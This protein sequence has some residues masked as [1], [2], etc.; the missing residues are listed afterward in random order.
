MKKPLF[1]ILIIILLIS[2][3]VF[4]FACK[5]EV[6]IEETVVKTPEEDPDDEVAEQS[7]EDT[8]EE[9][10]GETPEEEAVDE[11]AQE[12]AET[13]EYSIDSKMKDLLD[14]PL[15]RKVLEKYIPD[16]VNSDRIDESRN[17]SLKL[18]LNFSDVEEDIIPLLDEA[19]K[20][21][22]S[23]SV[24]ATQDVNY[25][26]KFEATW[27]SD[28]HPDDYDSSAHFSPFVIYSY[29]GTDLGRIFTVDSIS[30]P[31]M[32]EMAETGAIGMLV[33]EIRQIIDSNNALNYA[34]AV[35]IDS[36]GQTEIMLN[37][38][39]EFSQ[40]M[41]V[42]MIAPSPDWFVAAEADLFKEG[43]WVD[44]IILDVISFDAGTDSGDS[45]TA[46]NS[47]TNPKQTISRF[48]DNLQKLGIITITKI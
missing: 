18:V 4:G 16:V 5:K 1:T 22:G 44:K 21:V 42:S 35:K 26:I 39:Q 15:T 13:I 8:E 3:A 47:D 6:P 48:D 23:E 31:G 11:T 2:I 19:L 37:F 7:G 43:Q 25:N 9:P 38:T 12:E 34:K 46:E 14:N 41:F 32:K 17:Y 33:E 40:F 45:L 36:P 28:S 27:S 30:S 20:N 10:I 29:N 24:D